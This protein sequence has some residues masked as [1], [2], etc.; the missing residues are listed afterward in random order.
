[1]RGMVNTGRLITA[2]VQSGAID[3]DQERWSGLDCIIPLGAALFFCCSL[4]VFDRGQ[5]SWHHTAYA[6]LSLP[7][8]P[9]L[10]SSDAD[11]S[12][13]RCSVRGFFALGV[14]QWEKSLT[15]G[16]VRRGQRRP[17]KPTETQTGPGTGPHALIKVGLEQTVL[18]ALSTLLGRIKAPTV[19]SPRR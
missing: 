10:G 7:S 3:A 18:P 1:M 15:S 2:P 17:D 4:A 19:A 16:A 5:I 8:C 14:E 13:E 6:A 9:P 11:G 12:P